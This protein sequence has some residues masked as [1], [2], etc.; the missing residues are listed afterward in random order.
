M[1]NSISIEEE[2]R[3]HNTVTLYPGNCIDLLRTI[4]DNSMQLVVTSPPY[5]IGKEYEKRRYF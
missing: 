1:S 4:P 5:N 2:Y 3:P